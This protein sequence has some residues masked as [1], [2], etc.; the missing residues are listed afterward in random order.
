MKVHLFEKEHNEFL[1]YIRTLAMTVGELFKEE[2]L[3]KLIGISRRKVRKYT[4]ILVKEQMIQA[5]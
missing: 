1:E 2:K 3:A 4:E 5:V